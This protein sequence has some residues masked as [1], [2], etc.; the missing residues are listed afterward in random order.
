MV[1]VALRTNKPLA[2]PSELHTGFR[3]AC[4][5][6]PP[7]AA[8]SAAGHR[9]AVPSSIL[10]PPSQSDKSRALHAYVNDLEAEKVQLQR[11]LEKQTAMVEKLAAEHHDATSQFAAVAEARDQLESELAECRTALSEQ[12]GSC[13][14]CCTFQEF[15][16]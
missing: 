11:G 1:T 4:S 8:T 15:A 3:Q 7:S 14:A 13:N 6:R 2:G 16:A 10:P 5:C 9:A 12:V